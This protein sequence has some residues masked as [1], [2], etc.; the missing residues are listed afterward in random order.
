MES[1]RAEQAAVAER[2]EAMSRGQAEVQ[3]RVEAVLASQAGVEERIEAVRAQQ[4]GVE[5]RFEALLAQQDQGR[6]ALTAKPWFCVV[7]STLP[8]VYV[9]A[10]ADSRRG[11]RT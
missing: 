8:V 9:H 11:G 6:Q 1:L 3:E 7:I 4:A 10:P 2:F 5:E